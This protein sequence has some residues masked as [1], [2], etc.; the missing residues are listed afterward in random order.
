MLR[1]PRITFE[2]VDFDTPARLAT[3]RIVGGLAAGSSLSIKLHR[4]SIGSFGRGSQEMTPGRS[5][6]PAR[7]RLMHPT[8]FS[9]RCRWPPPE[10]EPPAECRSRVLRRDLHARSRWSSPVR[11]PRDP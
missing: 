3:S 8:L 1:T 11:L 5:A 4:S 7:T 6:T 10:D 2:T 9:H